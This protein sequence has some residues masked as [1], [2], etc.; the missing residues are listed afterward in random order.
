MNET[1][2]VSETLAV[3]FRYIDMANGWEG[4]ILYASSESFKSYANFIKYKSN[5]YAQQM[6]LVIL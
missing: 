2:T 6:D 3:N 1:V 5:L 4:F